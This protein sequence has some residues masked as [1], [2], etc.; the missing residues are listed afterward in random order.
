MDKKN[1]IRTEKQSD[2]ETHEY[3]YIDGR[4]H[5]YEIDGNNMYF[6]YSDD[7]TPLALVYNGVKYYYQTN[8]Q[9]DVIGLINNSGTKV[10]EYTYDAWGNP[11]GSEPTTAAG[12]NN[13]LRYRGYVYDRDTGWYYLNSRY[14]NPE[15]G[16]FLN[17]DDVAYL[18]V[19]GTVLGYN[20][21]A[22]CEND[23]VNNID[24]FG[25][26]II[27]ISIGGAVI[28]LDLILTIVFP[29]IF[30]A[31]STTRLLHISKMFKFTRNI[32]KKAVK[33]LSSLFYEFMEN[34]LYKV[35]G[36]IAIISTKSF[37]IKRIE[38]YFDR[39]CKSNYIRF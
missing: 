11:T 20:L 28:L 5:Y 31:H 32:Y 30:A 36:R 35:T 25:M 4:L 2:G 16:R 1:E 21:L 34:I 27:N 26:W 10:A 19:S 37:T 29:F 8:L 17:A 7:G 3:A 6:T 23:P 12:R 15:V 13:P 22:Y 14:Y 18:G 33:K 38:T 39:D 24:P 9:G